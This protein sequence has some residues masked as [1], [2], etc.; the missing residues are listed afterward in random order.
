MAAPTH[1][2]GM[3]RMGTPTAVHHE[4]AGTKYRS[5]ANATG[6]TTRSA[7]EIVAI[8]APTGRRLNVRSTTSRRVL[9]CPAATCETGSASSQH[10]NSTRQRG[11]SRAISADWGCRR[12][13]VEALAALGAGNEREGAGHVVAVGACARR[14]FF[15]QW[16]QAE[17]VGARG[18]LNVAA[19]ARVL[20]HDLERFENGEGRTVVILDNRG[21]SV[22]EGGH[23]HGAYDSAPHAP[24]VASSTA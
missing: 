18:G 24:E 13:P 6:V 15:A 1:P 16:V 17:E 8:V 11:I 22:S 20:A 2:Q 21:V 12:I 9:P 5:T 3:T 7:S 10:P 23:R 14:I 19:L 4:D